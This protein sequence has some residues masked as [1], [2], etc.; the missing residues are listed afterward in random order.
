MVIR[1]IILFNV[2]LTRNALSMNMDNNV[3]QCLQDACEERAQISS[4]EV[5]VLAIK[6]T[7]SVQE[8]QLLELQ[9]QSTVIQG[10]VTHLNTKT[11]G[12]EKEVKSVNSRVDGVNARLIVL[13]NTQSNPS[14]LK[15]FTTASKIRIPAGKC[16]WVQVYVDVS[17]YRKD[18]KGAYYIYAILYQDGVPV[19]GGST[20]C[21][22]KNYAST[23]FVG[24]KGGGRG[25]RWTY[26]GSTSRMFALRV[27][28]SGANLE[29]KTCTKGYNDPSTH[30]TVLCYP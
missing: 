27:N 6:K 4:L 30:M 25:H 7:S 5:D 1:I 10:Q 2:I 16:S 17:G 21:S 24:S 8:V 20:A 13:E 9:D 26:G 11:D 12:F 19:Y 15:A 28:P 29:L 14:L 3:Y 23:G 22:H 18:G